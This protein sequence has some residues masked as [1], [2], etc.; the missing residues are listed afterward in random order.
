MSRQRRRNGKKKK[1]TNERVHRL[2]VLELSRLG[3][4]VG[5][6]RAVD[7]LEVFDDAAAEVKRVSDV[8]RRGRGKA[9]N[10]P[11]LG[12][13]VVVGRVAAR[14]VGAEEGREVKVSPE[15]R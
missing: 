9:E 1:G 8:V 2:D 11:E 13:E 5:V 14:P 4:G 10:E 15:S 6:S 3:V 12:G 7:A